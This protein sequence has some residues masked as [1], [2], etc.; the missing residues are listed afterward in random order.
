MRILIIGP[1]GSGKTTQA[2][3]LA[4]KFNLYFA[5]TGDLLREEVL[6]DSHEG[7]ILKKSLETGQLADD[8]IVAKLLKEKLGGHLQGF[9]LDGYPRSLDQL[10]YF[11]PQFDKVIYLEI[12]D[13]EVEKRLLQ[14]GRADDTP[15]LIRERLRLYHELTEPVLRYYNGQR[16]LIRIDGRKSIEGVAR[17]IERKLAR[18]KNEQAG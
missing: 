12:S 14:R 7:R 1:Q 6:R 2:K 8:R 16:K 11:D 9:V 18:V 10:Q 17:E 5:S 4:E 13:E 3:N 15:E